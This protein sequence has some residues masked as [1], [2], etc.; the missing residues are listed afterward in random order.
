MKSLVAK[1]TLFSFIIAFLGINKAF[2]QEFEDL[3]RAGAEDAE[4]YLENYIT[5]AVNSFGNGMAGGWYN[6]AKAH[7]TLGF[8]F[9]V[10]LNV[11]I[12]SNAE[13]MFDFNPSDYNNLQLRNDAD[14]VLPT[15]VGGD[16]EPG[17]ELY[18]PSDVTVIYPGGQS[19][20]LE[21]EVTFPVP[22]GFNLDK[23][24]VITGVPT[25]TFNLGIGI[26][27][28]TDLKIRLV[29][30]QKYDNY[31][32]KMFGIGVLHDIKQWIPGIKN[33]PFD[34]SGFFGTTTLTSEYV[35]DI[36]E[37]TNGAEATTTFEGSGAATF[38]THAT[39]IQAVVSK[40]LLFFTPY[41]ALGFNVVKTT[42][43][44]SGDYTYTVDPTLGTPQTTSVSDP[45]GLE[46]TGAGGVRATLGARF[47]LAIFT[48]HGAYTIQKYN[49]LSIG[50][51]I[52][53]R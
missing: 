33:L 47:K 26:Y 16:P 20:T 24:P 50:V 9:T 27:K 18:V 8:D 53:V 13:K 19:I 38:K 31:R 11:V 14:E 51:G 6:T 4:T 2:S 43:D 29:P 34:L 32:V 22:P 39:T 1:F 44:V 5:P 49:N 36:N 7:K 40:K 41:A 28:N 12:V 21:D 52:S 23:A 42:F 10:S 30:E 17:S 35:I 3:L 46:F 25:P 37:V 45:I 48:F 15:L